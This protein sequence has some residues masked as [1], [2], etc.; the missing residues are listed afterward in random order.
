MAM[1]LV[2]S[3][4]HTVLKSTKLLHEHTIYILIYV[5]ACILRAS[6]CEKARYFDVCLQHLKNLTIGHWNHRCMENGAKFT[7]LMSQIF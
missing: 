5:H 4:V 6:W 1:S 2:K 3:K 7:H